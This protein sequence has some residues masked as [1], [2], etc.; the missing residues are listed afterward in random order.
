[1]TAN[2]NGGTAVHPGARVYRGRN[3]EEVLPRI[4]NEL[5]AHAIVTRQREGLAGGIGGFFQRRFI[6]IEAVPGA[7]QVDTYDVADVAAPLLD[8]PVEEG[9][10]APGIQR[11][12]QQ[13]APFA[14]QLAEAEVDVEAGVIAPEVEEP[15]PSPQ[16]P[17][18]SSEDWEPEVEEDEPVAEAPEAART[19]PPSA[20]SVEA[21]LV[22]AGLS[23]ELA[24]SVVG[25]TVSHSVPFGTPRQLR[26]LVRRNLALRLPVPPPVEGGGRIVAFVGAGGAGK[27]RAAARLAQAYAQ[28][29]DVPVLCLA[30]RS[31]DGGAELSS[32][33]EGTDVQVHPVENA[34]EVKRRIKELGGPALVVIDT[35]GASPTSE[36]EVQ[37]LSKLLSAAGVEEVHLALPAPLGMQAARELVAGVQPLGVSHIALTH[38]DETSHVGGAV[39]VSIDSGLPFSYVSSG[40][41]EPGQLVPA[42]AEALAASV[43]G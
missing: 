14:D 20:D 15:I 37:L 19:R 10:Q 7:Q 13:A 12:I 40:D 32:L 43:V 4:R 28:G 34:P 36:K 3:L 26:R 35:A 31:G 8:N 25:Q 27:T 21:S 17:V 23:P 38:A 30:L 18:H 2:G 5:G 41:S 39:Q 16:S 6:E 33:L 11:A 29:S 1:M 42:E 22:A 24:A 9:L